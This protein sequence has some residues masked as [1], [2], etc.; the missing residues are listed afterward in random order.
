VQRR[1]S[2]SCA[3]A[4][5]EPSAGAVE[6]AKGSTSPETGDGGDCRNWG[7]VILLSM[8]LG[9]ARE[10]VA[11]CPSIALGTDGVT[12]V[13]GCERLEAAGLCEREMVDSDGGSPLARGWRRK[14]RALETPEKRFVY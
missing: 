5:G 12:R 13:S 11:A 14:R 6:W 8:G 9:V 7:V 3:V 2:W 1:G 4:A 10:G